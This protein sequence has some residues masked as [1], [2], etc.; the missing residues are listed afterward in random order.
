LSADLATNERTLA[1]APPTIADRTLRSLIPAAVRRRA[2]ATLADPSMGPRLDELER[3]L[4][5]RIGRLE[6][7]LHESREESW[8]RSRE[9]WRAA[10]PDV[11]L[12]WGG[13]ISGEP[14]ISAS[15]HHGGFGVGRTIVEIGPGYGRLLSAA[16]ELGVEYGSWVGVDLSAT[17]VAHL[18]NRFPQEQTQFI[19]G[20]VESFDLGRPIDT[21]ISSLTFKH[22]YPS[23]QVALGNLSRQLAAGGLVIFD[24]IEG[25]GGHFEDDGVTY[26]RAYAREEIDRLVMAEG[27]ERVAF[28]QVQHHPR[29]ARLLVVARKP[30]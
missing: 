9:R 23:F 10:R 27:L 2:R 3:R 26:I 24:L 16:I 6:S 17:N 12:T 1:S 7:M 15:A 25:H 13:E 5:A 8:S 18:A 19:E 20:D 11:D 28:D 22:L 4:D 29:M 14:F 21:V 30:A